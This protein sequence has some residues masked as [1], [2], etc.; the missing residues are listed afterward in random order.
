MLYGVPFLEVFI[1]FDFQFFNVHVKIS[2]ANCI[3]QE[4]CFL[5]S[6]HY[7]LKEKKEQFIFE[8]TSNLTHDFFLR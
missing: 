5:F 6:A 7:V 1:S 2:C 8:N 3:V 4:K